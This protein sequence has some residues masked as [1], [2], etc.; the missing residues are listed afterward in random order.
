V[1]DY[2]SAPGTKGGQSRGLLLVFP[3]PSRKLKE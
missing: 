3:V 1:K 2:D